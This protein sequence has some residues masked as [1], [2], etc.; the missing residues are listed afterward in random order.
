M[1]VFLFLKQK[2]PQKKCGLLRVETFGFVS[3]QIQKKRP[4]MN[5]TSLILRKLYVLK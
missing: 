4:Q 3:F 2:R 5:A 1:G